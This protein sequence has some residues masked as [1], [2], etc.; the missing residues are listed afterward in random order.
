MR[1][2]LIAIFAVP[3]FPS[4]AAADD[5]VKDQKGFQGTWALTRL[6][7]EGAPVP[8]ERIEK[9]RFIVTDNKLVMDGL[10]GKREFSFALD[11]T[12]TPKQIDLTPL[13]GPFKGKTTPAI[14]SLEG[15]TLKICMSNKETNVRPTEFKSPKD[16]GLAVFTLKRAKK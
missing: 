4:A 13:D 6:D 2:A 15:D 7:W 9:V 16:S 10:D 8:A 1:I 12:K 3:L 11:A 5:T 14:Y